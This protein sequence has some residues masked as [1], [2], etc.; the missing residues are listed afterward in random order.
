MHHFNSYFRPENYN[1]LI[2]KGM[3]NAI[4]AN[5]VKKFNLIE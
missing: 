5:G 1:V 2:T 3:T 4:D